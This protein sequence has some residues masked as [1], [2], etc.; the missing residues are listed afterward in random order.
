MSRGIKDLRELICV[1]RLTYR[2]SDE[3][4]DLSDDEGRAS[5]MSML[6]QRLEVL[7]LD[8]ELHSRQSSATSR[9]AI[10]TTP[11]SGI[12]TNG[13]PSAEGYR[14]PEERSK[15]GKKKKNKKKPNTGTSHHD[16]LTLHD[17]PKPPPL[18]PVA[19]APPSTDDGPS[20]SSS[21]STVASPSHPPG[22]RRVGG[23]KGPRVG[24]PT[25]HHITNYDQMMSYLDP[26]VVGEW[27][28]LATRNVQKLA[29]W[30]HTRDNFVRFAHFWLNDFSDLRKREIFEL[31]HSILLDNLEYGFA[32]GRASAKV[33]HK[34]LVQ[35]LSAIF[36]EYPAKVLSASGPH[37]FLDY[38]DILT[39]ERTKSYKALLSDV[40][41]S[42]KNRQFAQLVLACRCFTLVSV[43]NAVVNFYRR[44]VGDEVEDTNLPDMSKLRPNNQRMYLAVR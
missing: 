38:L 11:D 40:K 43:W 35:F 13:H 20:S 41:C 17:L 34:D 12:G 27:L 33:K 3:E 26:S 8:P 4:L 7:S 36:R 24:A 2:E 15:S 19:S 18:P 44:L 23:D 10:L 1:S 39:S 14:K 25:R 32:Q 16:L 6:G 30:A 37:M 5:R 29:Q 42:T 9:D 21:E 31:E 22:L 28:E